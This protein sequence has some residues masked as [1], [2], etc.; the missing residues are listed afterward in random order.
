[1]AEP[2]SPHRYAAGKIVLWV[3]IDSTIDVNRGLNALLDPGVRKY[4]H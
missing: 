2:G 4:R 3:P 1:L